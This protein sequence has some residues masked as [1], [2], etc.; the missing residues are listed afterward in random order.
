MSQPEPR[1]VALLLAVWAGAMLLYC[2]TLRH[3][4][5]WDDHDFVFGQSFLMDCRNLPKAASPANFLG[6]LQVRNSARPAWLVSVL[7]DTC[8]G[9]GR[10]AAYR[11]TSIF[12]HA[13]GAVLVMALAWWLAGDL[14]AAL[15]AGLLFAVHPVHTEA[16]NIIGFRSDLLAL[17]FML[18][19]LLLYLEGRRRAGWRQG[20]AFAASLA[21][22]A[23]A[24]LSKEMAVTLPILAVL[25]EALF[26][27]APHPDAERRGRAG[28]VALLACALALVPLYLVFRAPRSGYVSP[29]HQDV[30]SA[31]RQRVSLPFSKPLAEAAPA[32]AEPRARFEDPPWQRVY[33]DGGVR[34]LT[35]SRVFG[36]YLRLL[37]WPWPL[38]G[39][40]APKVVESWRQ[41][42]LLASW[43]AWLLLLAGAWTLRR[44]LPLAAFGLAWTA[45]ALLPV[46]GLVLLRNLQAERYLYVPSAGFCLAV[47]ALGAALDRRLGPGPWR[48]ACRAAFAAVLL[49]WG[50]RVWGRNRDFASDLAFFRATEAVD[51]SVPRVRLSLA[52]AYE[53][54]GDWAEAD[55]EFAASLALW[56]RYRKARLLYADF[57]GE[58][59]RGRESLAQLRQA[60]DLFPDD[61]GVRQ[62]LELSCRR[63]GPGVCAG[64][65]PSTTRPSR[66]RRGG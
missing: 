45:A 32:A 18:I 61:P 39:D 58:R 56:P 11:L 12:W 5:V 26:P 65:R 21:A 14:A 25:A 33:D 17:A 23:L 4:P 16:V 66:K 28:R 27:V 19:S 31:W 49:I 29:E 36:S 22:F 59:G 46:S 42:T 10:T 60:E 41:P 48:P 7:A 20:A 53:A 37:V 8:L 30:F 50:W 13:V 43:A 51:P 54:R 64:G 24:L 38:Q 15:L 55:R 57:L 2:G 6:V 63:L 1:R 9:G 52:L 35:M 34:F 40:Y 3:P 47:G 44:R 62:R